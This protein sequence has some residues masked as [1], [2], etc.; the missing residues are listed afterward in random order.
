MTTLNKATSEAVSSLFHLAFNHESMEGDH[1][2]QSRLVQFAH[3]NNLLHLLPNEAHGAMHEASIPHKHDGMEPDHQHEVVKAYNPIGKDFVI[4]KS[5]SVDGSPDCYIEGWV[6][7]P[8]EDREKDVIV[9]GAFSKAMDNYFERRAPISYIHEGKSL[10]AGHLQR[11]AT[12]IDGK[13][14]K[15][16][17]H[18]TD[19][20]DFEDFPAAGNGTYIRAVLNAPP[21][22][23]SVRKGNC[24]GMSFIGNATSYSPR[25]PRG[26]HITEINPW[27]ESTVAPYPINTKA[28]ITIAKAYGLEEPTEKEHMSEKLE[29]LLTRLLEQGE[30]ETPV[31]K[32][33]VTLEALEALLTKNQ[34]AILEKV[35]AKVQKAV[36]LVRAEGQGSRMPIVKSVLPEENP[37]YPIVKKAEAGEELN[38]GELHLLNAATHAILAAGMNDSGDSV[39]SD[40]F[41]GVGI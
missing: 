41:K 9:A 24:G 31:Q 30:A 29:Q 4:S 11:A 1:P 8:D 21:V 32:S 10:P 16:V 35:D 14:V 28:I 18:P 12:V 37:L 34:E 23:E 39:M 3:E 22:A 27:I 38:E 26:R 25:S 15:S 7:T 6:S 2:Q 19:P 13:I 33:E 20:A 36:D 17:V 40:W 5:W